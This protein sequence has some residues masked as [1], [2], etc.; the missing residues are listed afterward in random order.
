MKK[1]IWQMLTRWLRK[2][3]RHFFYI[4]QGVDN[5][6]P[7]F[8]LER[9]QRVQAVSSSFDSCV[10]VGQRGRI[11]DTL[12]PMG[13]NKLM[14]YTVQW[15][16]PSISDSTPKSLL[17]IP[18]TWTG[19][20]PWEMTQAELEEIP[21]FAECNRSV[22]CPPYQPRLGFIWFTG[23]DGRKYRVVAWGF[24]KLARVLLSKPLDQVD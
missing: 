13:A 24:R 18:E 7:S 19:P 22:H 20:K 3:S 8:T 23:T 4:E 9:F 16:E 14:R 1:T 15:G 11:W 5:P 2:F 12:R 6:A 10:R 17:A 21:Y